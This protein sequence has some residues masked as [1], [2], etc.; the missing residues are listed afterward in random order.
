MIGVLSIR[1]D[2]IMRLYVDP[3]WHRKGVGKRL[4]EEAAK[5]VKDKGFKKLVL[6]SLGTYSVPFYVAMRMKM[7][8][9]RVRMVRAGICF[10]KSVLELDL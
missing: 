5:V 1:G 10:T 8:K 6:S 3:L 2:E 4:F 7:V 9:E